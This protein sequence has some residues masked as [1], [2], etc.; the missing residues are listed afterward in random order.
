MIIESDGFALT[1]AEG[2]A[3]FPDGFVARR[4]EKQ[5]VGNE[6]EHGDFGI[7][8]GA[9]AAVVGDFVKAVREAA[10]V[11]AGEGASRSGNSPG[12]SFLKNSREGRRA[13]EGFLCAFLKRI[14]PIFL[15]LF[16]SVWKSLLLPLY[17]W[18]NPSGSAGFEVIPVIEGGA[19]LDYLELGGGMPDFEAVGDLVERRP[20]VSGLHY[21]SDL[22]VLGAKF[23]RN[24]KTL[25]R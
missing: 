11:L 13:G 25:S 14:D 1:L 6:A 18:L 24:G 21:P 16:P 9:G 20:D 2:G 5:A 12:G 10:E 15:G 4:T 22:P 23:G 3:G 17:P 7:T 19:Q 8:S